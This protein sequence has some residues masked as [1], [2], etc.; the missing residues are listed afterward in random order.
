MRS[1]SVADFY[2]LSHFESTI[3]KTDLTSFSTWP[4]SAFVGGFAYKH[5][6]IWGGGEELGEAIYSVCQPVLLSIAPTIV[7]SPHFVF[8]DG[9]PR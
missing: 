4:F 1:C 3:D 8:G 9:V 6:A 5:D 7:C 2:N